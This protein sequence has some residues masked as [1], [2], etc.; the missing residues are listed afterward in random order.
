LLYLVVNFELA[1]HRF[2]MW[3]ALAASALL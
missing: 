2:M 3:P 1:Q